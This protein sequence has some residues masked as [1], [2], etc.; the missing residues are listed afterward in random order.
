MSATRQFQNPCS[1]RCST[2]ELN[3]HAPKKRRQLPRRF[4]TPP[5]P[6]QGQARDIAHQFKNRLPFSLTLD[7]AELLGEVLLE[8]TG[9][10][11]DVG[12]GIFRHDGKWAVRETDD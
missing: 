10:I 2:Q 1:C 12:F 7:R 3:A 9:R 8:L 4:P 11:V 6:G 5:A